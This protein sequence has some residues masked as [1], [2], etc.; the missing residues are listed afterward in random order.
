MRITKLV[1]YNL[2]L[3]WLSVAVPVAKAQWDGGVHIGMHTPY[4][5]DPTLI[6]TTEDGAERQLE[7]LRGPKGLHLGV[8]MRVEFLKLYL[9]G[10]GTLNSTQYRYALTDL[11]GQ[12]VEKYLEEEYQHLSV[13]IKIGWDWG[14]FSTYVGATG[15]Y[16]LNH[17]SELRELL[18][19]DEKWR[20]FRWAISLGGMVEIWRLKLELGVEQGIGSWREYI[21]LYGHQYQLLD[22]PGRVLV[23]LYV[24]L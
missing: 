19:F 13:P 7:A 17:F 15:N 24:E 6:F 9:Q 5:L 3:F 2:V 20:E 1:I 4:F 18:Y 12:L 16:L 23:S 22:S 11:N 21:T 14:L 10:Q 8:W